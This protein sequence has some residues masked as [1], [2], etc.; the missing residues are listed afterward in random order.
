METPEGVQPAPVADT[1]KTVEE[2]FLAIMDQQ[3]P[4]KE[5][6]QPDASQ[7]EEAAEEAEVT[8]ETQPAEQPQEDSEE[9]DFEGERYLIP[10]PIKKAIEGYKDYTRKT[11]EVAEMRRLVESQ[12]KVMQEQAALQAETAEESQ[13]LAMLDASIKQYKR[14]DWSAMDT[15][16]I[17]KTKMQLDQLVESRND[18]AKAIDGKR[19]QFQSRIAQNLAAMRT[20]GDK[21]LQRAIAGWNQ[22]LAKKISES[23]ISYGFT[24]EE[25]ANVYDHRYVQVLHDAYQWRQ[26]QASKPE[27]TKRV[28]SVKGV[29]RPA[30]RNINPEVQAKANLKRALKLTKDPRQ[31][32]EVASQ[33]FLTKIR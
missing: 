20:E 28:E 3:A 29:A 15:D 8:A 25:L 24:P 18:L 5:Q 30:S 12:A 21:A 14:L 13:Q 32:M 9:M 10:K 27:V 6:P 11:Q 26:L 4:S 33:L 7:P 23:A 2:R 22:D 1:P 19:A 31:K 16:Q 17:V